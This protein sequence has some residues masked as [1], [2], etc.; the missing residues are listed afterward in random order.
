MSICVY[1]WIMPSPSFIVVFL[2]LWIMN[3]G[4]YGQR[5]VYHEWGAMK[6]TTHLLP[7]LYPLV[8]I[9]NACNKCVTLVGIVI[10]MK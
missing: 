4:I 1:L 9:I 8:F 5:L 6:C 2:S 7:L 3:Y 10:D